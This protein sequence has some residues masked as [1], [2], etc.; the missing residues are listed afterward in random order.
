[1]LTHAPLF[2]LV[3]YVNVIL[4][5]IKILS[6]VS[7]NESRPHIL[8]KVTDPVPE[9]FQHRSPLSH[10]F[11]SVI[12]SSNL[13]EVDGITPP[14]PGVLFKLTLFYKPHI[15]ISHF[16]CFFLKMSDDIDWLHSR[17]GVCKVDLYSP[18]GQQ[19]Q[20]RK[21]VRYKLTTRSIWVYTGAQDKLMEA[22]MWLL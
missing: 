8:T 2:L 3:S 20:D 9:K 17:R 11:F 21:V 6:T 16:F 5:W 18:K 7:L 4:A 12:L 22:D 13:Y 19:D 10:P 14:P 15:R 1:M